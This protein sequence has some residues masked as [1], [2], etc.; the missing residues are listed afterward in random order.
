MKSLA[1]T[2]TTI[3]LFAVAHAQGQCAE[4]I[5]AV[6]TCAVS[7]IAEAGAG[8]GCGLT[9]IACQC[10][11]SQSVA[12]ASAALGCVIDAC[13]PVTGLAVQSAGSAVCACAANAGPGPA[14]AP[15]A[16]A[17]PSFTDIV[18]TSQVPAL[19]SSPAVVPSATAPYPTGGAGGAPAPSGS[20][21]SASGGAGGNGGAGATGGTPSPPFTGGAPLVVGSV[22][23]LMGAIIAAIAA[24]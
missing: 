11:S 24:L 17:T 2:I 3:G 8:V 20:A 5:A 21:P 10:S 15:P 22:G 12:I 6:P 16:T 19:T 13:G 4:E 23:G 7:C 18:I 9:D 14:T 1:A